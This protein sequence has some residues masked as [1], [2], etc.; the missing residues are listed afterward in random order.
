[1]LRTWCKLNVSVPSNV[2]IRPSNSGTVESLCCDES[3]ARDFEKL[4]DT[5]LMSNAFPGRPSRESVQHLVKTCLEMYAVDLL[6]VYSPAL[7]N[8]RSMQLGL[9]STCVAADLETGWDLEA[10]SRRDKCSSEAQDRKP[11]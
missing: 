10:K 7:F 9:M 11:S 2:G 1:M 3:K 5:V 8:E 6:E 4:N